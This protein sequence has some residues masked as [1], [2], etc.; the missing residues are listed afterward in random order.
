MPRLIDL[1]PYTS[2]W[3]EQ[4]MLINPQQAMMTGT[5]VADSDSK[6]I[7]CI[8]GD[9]ALGDFAWSKDDLAVRVCSDCKKIQEE[10]NNDTLHPVA[11]LRTR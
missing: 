3:F 4:L 5:V 8:C 6:N 2:A 9:V 11:Q 7:C 1:E 10:M